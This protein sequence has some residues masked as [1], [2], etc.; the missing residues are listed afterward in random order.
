M[1]NWYTQSM[2]G[3]RDVFEERS[4]CFYGAELLKTFRHVF[5]KVLKCYQANTFIYRRW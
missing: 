1:L 4:L 2:F 3:S 5:T